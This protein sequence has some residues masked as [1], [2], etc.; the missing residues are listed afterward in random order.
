MAT[1]PLITNAADGDEPSAPIARDYA[2][3][4]AASPATS[5]EAIVFIDSRV[6]DI[7]DL[8]NGLAPHTAAFVIDAG[9]D[10]LEQI[11]GIL[12]TLDAHDLKGVSLVGH[13]AAGEIALGSTMLTDATLADHS[14]ALSA[15]GAALAPG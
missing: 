5:V 1:H 12:G 6:P 14:G 13:G 10:G 7:Q 3:I 9:R 11:A 15:I 4:P 8:L 2:V